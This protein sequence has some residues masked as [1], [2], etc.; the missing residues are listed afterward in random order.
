[1]ATYLKHHQLERSP[2]EGRG[3]DQLVLATASLRRAYAEI[4]SGIDEDSPRVCITGGSGI[5]KS[6]L[7]RA[8]P[9]LLAA[10]ARCVLI[11]DPSVDWERV[12]ASIAKQLTLTGGQTSRTTLLEARAQGRKLVLVIDNAEDLPSESLDHLDVLLGYRDDDGGPLVQCVLLAN[13]DEAPRGG[14]LPILWWLDGLATRQLRFSPIPEKGLRSYIDKHLTKA[15]WSGGSLFTDDAIVAIHRY[16]GGVPGAVSALCEELL[17]RSAAAGRRE[18]D[19]RLVALVCGDELPLVEETAKKASAAPLEIEP[20]RGV[21]VHAPVPDSAPQEEAEEEMQIHQGFLPMDEPE[22]P[23]RGDFFA[24]ERR[25]PARDSAP[26]YAGAWGGQSFGP[27]PSPGSGRT[28]RMVRNLTVLAV[29][30]CVAVGVHLYLSSESAP[31]ALRKATV[32]PK[33][34]PAAPAPADLSVPPMV[35][36][37]ERDLAARSLALENAQDRKEL[38]MAAPEGLT[39]DL[40]LDRV[41][42]STAPGAKAASPDGPTPVE[43]ELS[44]RD[45]YEIAEK[46]K[47][48]PEAFEPWAEQAPEDEATGTPAAPAPNRP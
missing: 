13:L 33:P 18:I 20:R 21:P 7:A 12:K 26:A 37:D 42:A 27:E 1:M 30:A 10:D 34:P 41:S 6:S 25:A 22:P 24:D 44:L 48:E 8:L 23:K 3:S 43:R 11:R 35:P 19:A 28:A 15:G 40:K 5:G 17:S 47:Q 2:F 39:S 46:T 4:K 45:L 14:D 16:T 32:E 38:E 29:L 36:P 9:K 31:E